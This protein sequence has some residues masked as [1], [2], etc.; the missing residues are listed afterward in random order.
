MLNDVIDFLTGKLP[1]TFPLYISML[2]CRYRSP[3]SDLPLGKLEV[4]WP[5]R[6]LRDLLLISLVGNWLDNML[7]DL[8]LIDYSTYYIHYALHTSVFTSCA[9]LT[10]IWSSFTSF[11][12]LLHFIRKVLHFSHFI[13]IWFAVTELTNSSVRGCSFSITTSVLSSQSV[14]TVPLILSSSSSS[15]GLVVVLVF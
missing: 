2:P 8:C 5:C 11:R 3:S 6:A 9:N 10:R 7:I 14:R 13:S 15:S 12:S 4:W 1:N